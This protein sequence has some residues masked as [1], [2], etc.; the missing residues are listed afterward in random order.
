MLCNK[1]AEVQTGQMLL[2]E[3]STRIIE[4]EDSPEQWQVETI[5]NDLHNGVGMDMAS[6]NGAQDLSD[7]RER[8]SMSN[9]S[10]QPADT[11]TSQRSS[12]STNLL[13][14]D[15]GPDLSQQQQQQQQQQQNQQSFVPFTS[16]QFQE[17]TDLVSN[18]GA[19]FDRSREADPYPQLQP[20][21]S[22]NINGSFGLTNVTAED[23]DGINRLMT[24]GNLWDVGIGM[25]IEGLG[26][27]SETVE[28]WN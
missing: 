5:N 26:G 8:L 4:E 28:Q 6:M 21:Y 17:S 1:I 12:L 9:Y 7:Q 23:V 27:S 18:S 16:W 20:N 15:R 13:S 25:R 24:S 14:P 11:A 3:P 2:V 22:M 19:S 10:D